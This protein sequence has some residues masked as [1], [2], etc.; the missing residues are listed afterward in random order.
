[1]QTPRLPPDYHVPSA[2]SLDCETPL[3]TMCARAI[4]LGLPELCFTEHLDFTPE[5]EGVGYFQP[6]AY[7][8]EL[9]RCR[10]RYGDQ[11]TI[12]AGVE[13]AEPHRFPTE[14]AAVR[15]AWPFDFVLGSLHWIGSE[16]AIVP[17]YFAGKDEDAAY[18]AYFAELLDVVRA[19]GFDVLAHLDV[20]KRAGYDVHGHSYDLTRHAEALD[21]VLRECVE[22]GIGLEIN[23]GPLR[24]AVAE[25][26]P[27]LALLRRYRELGGEILTLGSDAHAPDALGHRFD[28]ALDLA[29]AAGFR[30]LTCFERRQPRFVA[31]A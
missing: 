27:P 30:R 16:L 13:I 31:I 21:A 23:T 26:A 18:G 11:L 19:G 1:M 24:R 4:A 3:A 15:D 8:A 6:A 12:R 28:L 2:F 17:E 25:T 20:L 22:Q 5:D 7:F 14:A 10:T 9:E 29:R